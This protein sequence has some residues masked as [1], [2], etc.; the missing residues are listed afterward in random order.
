MSSEA[1]DR[2]RLAVAASRHG[3]GPTRLATKVRR[4]GSGVFDEI[5]SNLTSD[6][7]G[8]VI[9]EAELLIEAGVSAVLLGQD[10]YPDCLAQTRAAPPVL[11]L[12]GPLHL[13]CQ[14]SLGVCGS[15]HA[16]EEGLRAAR[17][18]A[19]A[20][21]TH[22]FNVVSG[23][24]RGV[25]MASHTA[26]LTHGGNTVIVLA[27]GIQ[28]FRVR[29]GEFA[30]AWDPTR[31][32]VV[33]QFASTQPWNAGSAMARNVVIAELS[34]ALVVVEAGATG[35]TLAAGL[36]ALDR[37]QPVVVLQLSDAPAGN[38][39]L[40]QK[41]AIRIHSREELERYLSDLP[42]TTGIQPTL[43]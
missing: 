37:G 6:Q 26:A 24:A 42:A 33:S 16:S 2:L 20:G 18:C 39:L 13:L 34:K 21:A 1:P 3:G 23:Y 40:E 38:Q 25:D 4:E 35:G 29:R 19:E 11:F 31:A 7:A 9:E 15:R 17:A 32:V 43:I 8:G 36:H 10:G 22:G 30:D 14:P 27:E 28:H 41:G 5:L 12:R